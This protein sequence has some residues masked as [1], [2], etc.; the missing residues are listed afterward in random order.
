MKGAKY[1]IRPSYTRYGDAIFVLERRV[2][3]FFWRTLQTSA[4]A[5]YLARDL[6]ARLRHDN[7]PTQGLDAEGK[8]L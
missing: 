1:R 7:T 3:R 5:G 4:Y 2:L 6:K 8:P